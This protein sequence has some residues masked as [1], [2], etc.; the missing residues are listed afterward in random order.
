MSI[1]KLKNRMNMSTCIQN[2]KIR[3]KLTQTVTKSTT[4]KSARVCKIVK[5]NPNQL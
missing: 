2:P 3:Q 4:V 5:L 1:G